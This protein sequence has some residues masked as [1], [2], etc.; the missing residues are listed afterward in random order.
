MRR[1]SESLAER[2]AQTAHARAT[3]GTESEKRCFATREMASPLL[4]AARMAP[5]FGFTALVDRC[6]RITSAGR[7]GCSVAS[8][9]QRRES[10][11]RLQQVSLSFAMLDGRNASNSAESSSSG[12]VII[13]SA[14]SS[15]QAGCSATRSCSR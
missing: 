6:A 10:T 8:H 3:I 14:S 9:L 12:T 4:S 11:P 1:T 15:L 5:A 13:A 2:L 7:L